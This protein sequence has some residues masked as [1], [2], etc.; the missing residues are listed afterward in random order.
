MELKL[1]AM[2]GLAL[3]VGA[4][5]MPVPDVAEAQT[6][7]KAAR[8]AP[9]PAQPA[10]DGEAGEAA[11]A[12]MA[13]DAGI[14]AWQSGKADVAVEQLN[15]SVLEGK[16]SY[17]QMAKALYVRG[18]AQR[19]L[20]KPA[21]AISDLQNALW[22]KG[23]LSENE[24]ADALA[25]R[26]AAYREAGIADP[27]AGKVSESVNKV[28]EPTKVSAAAPQRA[29]VAKLQPKM[30]AAPAP[31]PAAAPATEWRT[32]VREASGSSRPLIPETTAAVPTSAAASSQSP[33]A[34]PSASGTGSFLSSV[35]GDL[36][37]G[38]P[39]PTAPEIPPRRV[40][41]APLD[42]AG[43]WKP[44]DAG[45]AATRSV[46]PGAERVAAVAPA[47]TAPKAAV[48]APE[49][50]FRLQV[51]AV[52]SRQDADLIVARL[53]KEQGRIVAKRAIDVDQ[54]GP[55]AAQPG[56]WRVRLGPYATA[57]EPRNLCVKLRQVGYD[58]MVVTQ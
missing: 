36:S 30:S 33:A 52:K 6:S 16:L 7:Q 44:A 57:N 9:A 38:A 13:Y 1:R 26:S 32:S 17:Q 21:L 3:C 37:L 14:K 8:S 56:A 19:K 53:K 55:D 41:A 35:F 25:A 29:P 39:S 22:L 45:A 23:A 50:R 20:G 43:P 10:G 31:V 48:A 49:G 15:A 24:R 27:Q 47:E 34:S 54:A 11:T 40:A 28:A 58:C 42:G 18:L 46:S 12:A 2:V 51:G 4:L 5:G